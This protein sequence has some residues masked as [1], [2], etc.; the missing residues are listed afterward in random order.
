[1]SKYVKSVNGEEVPMTYEEIAEYKDMM[2]IHSTKKVCA[3]DTKLNALRQQRN[4]R[5]DE[6]DWTQTADTSLS[7]AEKKAW[8]KYRQELRDLTNNVD[9]DTKFESVEFPNPPK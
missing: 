7:A 6:C 3:F 5:L 2:A 8:V 1:M 9:K 4:V